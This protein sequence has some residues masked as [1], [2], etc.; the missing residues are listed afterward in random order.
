MKIISFLTISLFSHSVFAL[1]MSFDSRTGDFPIESV[2]VENIRRTSRG[3]LIISGEGKACVL[4]I[5]R[6]QVEVAMNSAY[7]HIL[8]HL[9]ADELLSEGLNDITIKVVNKNKRD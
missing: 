8:R 6:G 7:F 3:N 4:D 2:E 1:S 5:N 9:K